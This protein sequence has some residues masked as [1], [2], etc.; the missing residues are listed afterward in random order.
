MRLDPLIIALT[1]IAV[2]SCNRKDKD[3]QFHTQLEE[4]LYCITQYQMMVDCYR[5]YDRT[6]HPDYVHRICS[7]KFPH[8][9]CYYQ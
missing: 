2:T 9:G 1:V 6:Y 4:Q 8:N 7:Q 3:N 5:R